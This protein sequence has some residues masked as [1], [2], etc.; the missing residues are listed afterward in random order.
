[1]AKGR[2]ASDPR[3]HFVGRM[4]KHFRTDPG[5]LV[6]E[7]GFHNRGA[8]RQKRSSSGL[9]EKQSGHGKYFCRGPFQSYW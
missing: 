3:M 5:K 4:R 8:A 9:L 1:M 6:F 2:A 7:R